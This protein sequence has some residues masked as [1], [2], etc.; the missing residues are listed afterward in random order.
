MLIQEWDKA[1][2]FTGGALPRLVFML[3]LFLL[4]LCGLPFAPFLIRNTDIWHAQGFWFQSG[5]LLL[6]SYS[7]Y[8]P[9]EIRVKNLYLGLLTLWVGSLT[10]FASYQGLS[11]GKYLP[12]TL[13]PFFNFVCIL[14]FYQIIVQHLN[15]EMISK[16]LRCLSYVLV[17]TLGYCTLQYFGLG[18]GMEVIETK[19]I[20]YYAWF[21]HPAVTGFIGNPTHLSAYLGMCLPLLFMQRKPILSI[22]LLLF[23][24]LF[25]LNWGAKTVPLT[26]IVVSFATLGYYL[27]K[28]N[29]KN[30]LFLI[31]SIIVFGTILIKRTD[32]NYLNSFF[33]S[34]SRVSIWEYY[35]ELIKS[36]FIT[37]KGLGI[38][39]IL[40]KQSK[41]TDFRFLHNEYLHFLVEL[42]LVGV[43][44]IFACIYG[45]F[46]LKVKE[47]KEKIIL[48]ALFLGFII[49]SFT[50]YPAHL[51]LMVS[52]GILA[53][54]SKYALK[55]EELIWKPV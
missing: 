36:N 18:Q 8:K 5:I 39:N 41:W 47:S 16:I 40:A 22:S 52:I 14:L 21:K 6:F 30:F 29:R 50:L 17:I 46:K 44:S 4:V 19:H 28:T 42:G 34:Q 33:S 10:L 54:A 9:K 32:T 12:I 38:V 43:V 31:I 24:V 11:I 26:G 51:W 1:T 15:K 27:F 2:D 13:L 37:G 55:N 25:F 3:Y 53:Y 7:L 20:D 48:E 23:I 45:F 49:Q 35:F